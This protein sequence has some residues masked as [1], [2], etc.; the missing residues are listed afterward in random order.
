LTGLEAIRRVKDLKSLLPC[1]LLSADADED[2]VREALTAR[3]DTVLRK[4]VT[5]QGITSV[6]HHA[7]ERAWGWTDFQLPGGD[8][9]NMNR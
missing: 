1:I 8:P 9:F 2:L 5:R 4:P 6:V 3:A 7:L